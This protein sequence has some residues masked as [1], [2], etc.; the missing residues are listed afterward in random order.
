SVE[1]DEK[2]ALGVDLRA[3]SGALDLPRA[4]ERLLKLSA[5]GRYDQGAFT[6]SALDIATEAT[7]TELRGEAK[8]GTESG[9][10]KVSLPLDIVGRALGLSG[11]RGDAAVELSISGD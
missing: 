2:G 11:V 6:L 10:G 8:P 9:A 7:R 4:H 1:S 5:S 3:A